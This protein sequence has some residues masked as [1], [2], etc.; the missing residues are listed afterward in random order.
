M[1]IRCNPLLAQRPPE[2]AIRPDGDVAVS[3]EDVEKFV[4]PECPRC[5]GTSLKP[6]I[7]FFGDS[8]PREKVRGESISIV[9]I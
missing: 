5:G 2:E 1:L 4:M 6:R 3:A 7:V 9:L 8:V